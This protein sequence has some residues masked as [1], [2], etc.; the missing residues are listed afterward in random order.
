[1]KEKKKG[2]GGKE[3]QCQQASPEQILAT[4][5]ITQQ[6]ESLT[7]LI[8]SHSQIDYCYFFFHKRWTFSVTAIAETHLTVVAIGTCLSFYKPAATEANSQCLT[9]Q[10]EPR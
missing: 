4:L 5:N 2:G 3:W 9:V 1:M 7:C 6:P 10:L 8:S